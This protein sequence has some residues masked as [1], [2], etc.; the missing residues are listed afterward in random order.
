MCFWLSVQRGRSLSRALS[1][2]QSRDISAKLAQDGG[3]ERQLMTGGN[4][5]QSAQ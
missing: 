3:N 4:R 2:Q 5:W 1:L